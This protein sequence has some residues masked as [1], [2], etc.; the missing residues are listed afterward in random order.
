MRMES[1]RRRKLVSFSNLLNTKTLYNEI[2]KEILTKKKITK[3]VVNIFEIEFS[4]FPIPPRQ[5]IV[6]SL[7]VLMIFPY[8]IP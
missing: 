3:L 2:I 5:N 4:Q 7:I 6:C 8:S 1:Y